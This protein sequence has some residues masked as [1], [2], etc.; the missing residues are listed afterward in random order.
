MWRILYIPC[1]LIIAAAVAARVWFGK[2]VLFGKGGLSCRIDVDRWSDLLA[3]TVNLPTSEATAGELGRQLRRSAIVHWQQRDPQAARARD[4]AKRFAL[5]VPPLSI[6]IVLFALIAHRIPIPGAIAIFLAA[7]ALSSLLGML[8]IGA[9][10]RAVAVLART[11]RER[12]A[13]PRRD[14]E[15]AV[16]SCAVAEVWLD[17]LPPILRWI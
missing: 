2:K 14:D 4:A 5:A 6:A 8:S 1:I 3:T 9:E 10:L 17:A 12:R 15:D 16:I 13:F 7:T 11:L